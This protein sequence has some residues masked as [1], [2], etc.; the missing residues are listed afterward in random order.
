MS[1]KG[2]T[3]SNL[4][5]SSY[6]NNL[7][8]TSFSHLNTVTP[9]AYATNYSNGDKKTPISAKATTPS[10][11]IKRDTLNNN[12]V[13]YNLNLSQKAQTLTRPQRTTSNQNTDKDY[14]SSTLGSSL[15]K[16]KLVYTNTPNSASNLATKYN[17]YLA[18][19]KNNPVRITYEKIDRPHSA[20]P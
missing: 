12:L 18:Q 8:S 4:P 2:S 10:T 13:T 5:Y 6:L 9:S 1:T 14:N 7:F 11:S 3:D 17:N 20:T 15:T 19:A 16:S